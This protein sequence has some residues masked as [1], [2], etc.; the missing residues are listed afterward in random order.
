MRRIFI[1]Y[2]FF[3]ELPN[4][5]FGQ[6]LSLITRNVN[7]FSTAILI[8][9]NFNLTTGG[10]NVSDPEKYIYTLQTL[11]TYSND[12]VSLE[13]EL[14]LL[15]GDDWLPILPYDENNPDFEAGNA[16]YQWTH[17]DVE[18]GRLAFSAE[19]QPDFENNN[20]V[21]FQFKLRYTEN[22]KWKPDPFTFTVRMRTGGNFNVQQSSGADWPETP[23]TF[24]FEYGNESVDFI[25]SLSIGNPA[26]G[27]TTLIHQMTFSIAGGQSGDELTYTEASTIYDLTYNDDTPG[28]L[29]VTGYAPKGVYEDIFKSIGYAFTGTDYPSPNPRALDIALYRNAISEAVN[30]GVQA[31]IQTHFQPNLNDNG[32][33]SG[34]SQEFLTYEFDVTHPAGT[35]KTVYYQFQNLPTWLEWLPGQQKLQGYPNG[36]VVSGEKFNLSVSFLDIES[37]DHTVD[38]RDIRTK[39]YTI[40]LTDDRYQITIDDAAGLYTVVG[41]DATSLGAL[42]LTGNFAAQEEIQFKLA[43]NYAF[44]NETDD[45]T[46][47]VDANFTLSANNTEL[48]V[49]PS[50]DG[51]VMEISGLKVKF[52]GNNIGNDQPASNMIQALE[53]DSDAK[54]LSQSPLLAYAAPYCY[55]SYNPNPACNFEGINVRVDSKGEGTGYTVNVFPEEADYEE[56]S[57]LHTLSLDEGTALVPG[58]EAGSYVLI[59]KFKNCKLDNAPYPLRIDLGPVLKP[60]SEV[61]SFNGATSQKI[62]IFSGQYFN[63]YN[64]NDLEDAILHASGRG[65]FVENNIY[66]FDPSQVNIDEGTDI[67][68][69]VSAISLTG[70]CSTTQ[71]LNF[72]V[73]ADRF[74]NDFLCFGDSYT[75]IRESDVNVPLSSSVNFNKY[76]FNPWLNYGLNAISNSDVVRGKNL[77][78][79]SYSSKLAGLSTSVYQSL[80]ANHFSLNSNGE[81]HFKHHDFR[82]ALAERIALDFRGYIRTEI[83][84]GA[85]TWWWT[86]STSPPT[87]DATYRR[88]LVNLNL[89]SYIKAFEFS[90][91]LIHEGNTIPSNLYIG[92]ID[93]VDFSQIG[94]A[95]CSSTQGLEWIFHRFL[96]INSISTKVKEDPNTNYVLATPV[97]DDDDE[98]GVSRYRVNFNS[99]EPLFVDKD[100]VNIDLTLSY[101]Q[102]GCSSLFTKSIKITNGVPRPIISFDGR[103]YESEHNTNVIPLQ[104]CPGEDNLL[105]HAGNASY[106]SLWRVGTGDWEKIPVD[107]YFAV[108]PNTIDGKA[109]EVRFSGGCGNDF[110]A[111]RPVIKLDVEALEEKQ[112]NWE[113]KSYY[114][115]ND[116]AITVNY[117]ERI[118]GL[119]F[120]D[121]EVFDPAYVQLII[122]EHEGAE[123]ARLSYDHADI[124]AYPFAES[125]V[126]DLQLVY[127]DINDKDG[128]VDEQAISCEIYS[129]VVQDIVFRKPK[130]EMVTYHYAC[131]KDEEVNLAQFITISDKNGNPYPTPLDIKYHVQKPSDSEFKEQEGEDLEL[132]EHGEYLVYIVLSNEDYNF[133]YRTA[134]LRIRK[135][136]MDFVIENPQEK[137]C[138]DTDYWMI[139]P[140][141]ILNQNLDNEEAGDR[142]DD[143]SLFDYYLL[144]EAGESFNQDLFVIEEGRLGIDPRIT[145]KYT[146]H[147][148]Y[149]SSRNGDTG[150][151]CESNL[152]FD[153]EI[154]NNP[155]ATIGTFDDPACNGSGS[156]LLNTVV[157]DF[158]GNNLNWSDFPHVEY[159]AEEV[160]GLVEDAN[161]LLSDGREKKSFSKSTVGHFNIRYDV[162]DN[163]GCVSEAATYIEIKALPEPAFTTSSDLPFV[164]ENDEKPFEFINTSA[165]PEDLL[166]PEHGGQIT[167]YAWYFGNG[168]FVDNGLVEKSIKDEIGDTGSETNS[169]GTYENPKHFYTNP[170]EYEV[171]LTAYSEF[172]C[173]NTTSMKVE[174]GANPKAAFDSKAYTLGFPTTFEDHSSIETS[175]TNRKIEKWEWDFGNGEKV[176]YYSSDPFEYFNYVNDGTYNVKLILTSEVVGCKDT[177]EYRIPIFPLKTPVIDNAYETNFSEGN[178]G[179]LH[180]GQWDTEYAL[181]SWSLTDGSWQTNTGNHGDK[182]AP[183]ENTYYAAENSWIESPTIDL[184]QLELPMLSMKLNINSTPGVDGISLRY[185]CNEGKTWNTVGNIGE[186]LDWFTNE[187]VLSLPQDNVDRKIQGWSGKTGELFARIPLDE[188]Q[189]DAMTANTGAENPGDGQVRFRLWFASNNTVDATADYSG[190]KLEEFTISARNRLVVAEHFTHENA[191]PK[192]ANA[193]FDAVSVSPNELVILQ[194]GY[195]D[196]SQATEHLFDEGWMPA[197][198]RAL[199]YSI[200]EPNRVMVDGHIYE[201]E[202]WTESAYLQKAISQEKLEKARAFIDD[203]SE[204]DFLDNLDPK[205]GKTFINVGFETVAGLPVEKEDHRL[206]LHTHMVAG[207]LELPQTGQVFRNVVKEMLPD[208][209]GLNVK[210]EEFDEEGYIHFQGQIPWQPDHSWAYAE[211]VKM[212]QTVQGW[213]TDIIY[214]ARVFDIPAELIPQRPLDAEKLAKQLQLY[215]NPNQG[216]FTLEWQGEGKADAWAIYSTAG[217]KVAK[218]DFQFPSQTSQ[219]IAVDG[220]ADGLYVLMLMK[221]GKLITHKRL[222]ITH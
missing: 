43:D 136:K 151:S 99:L 122:S 106:E 176:T 14:Y 119:V 131:E 144:D 67:T 97:D 16:V 179:W 128:N 118:D 34:E 108:L 42:K 190:V 10:D 71:Y 212:I 4:F 88:V 208:A 66:Y 32:L 197:G 31:Q 165:M 72:R 113:A 8:A 213:D 178:A 209:A 184:S 143:L 33:I 155:V 114:F 120:P 52:T 90:F 214:Q 26:S 210:T 153:F 180:S 21:R 183:K 18:D 73:V 47:S 86:T 51:Q 45:L 154:F 56:D 63:D 2:L 28:A 167:R 82:E 202:K 101:K 89:Q 13:G 185:T 191:D 25:P 17:Q 92:D 160:D 29:T 157:Q 5:L 181:S 7:L 171:E 104:F 57:P 149:F 147:L 218:G 204:S 102:S 9:D 54:N 78:L 70:G 105:M 117:K 138:L 142:Y 132:R 194:Y 196:K 112:M 44:D 200:P 12:E 60:K 68:V 110:D 133:T 61:F 64:P 121:L 206:I 217:V 187:T 1:F 48:T 27:A 11:P 188:V 150:G 94:G 211:D 221:E 215:P 148:K 195:Q 127:V 80:I 116:E 177:V 74:A 15:K 30:E 166:N 23:P 87:S 24:N 173:E 192:E 85:Q 125:G 159:F 145:G 91:N 129:N 172:G 69:E 123:I 216:K 135:D 189:R 115:E 182:E 50:V 103:S 140:V 46:A 164:C 93:W 162:R 6:E 124:E 96:T 126:Y 198:A 65:V 203:I 219:M 137:L 199:H 35:S 84:T 163:N 83:A 158:Q 62:E 222:V 139:D 55:I 36:T 146:L 59:P 175:L 75:L 95:Y 107:D 170:N 77:I 100:E 79:S 220:L 152:Y 207:K 156:V 20:Q 39:E 141:M 81:L 134:T 58:L 76:V 19:G 40:T 37:A 111:D 201:R 169:S 98:S 193:L 205:T 22:E 49:T 174:L 186:G 38:A 3:L 168:F 130:L 109:L 41:C 53:I 161:A